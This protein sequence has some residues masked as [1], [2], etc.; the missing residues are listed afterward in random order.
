[1]PQA[2]AI[3][4]SLFPEFNVQ[5]PDDQGYGIRPAKK[6]S[7]KTKTVSED[8][9]IKEHHMKLLFLARD[10]NFRAII[11]S[12]NGMTLNHIGYMFLSQ[13]TLQHRYDRWATNEPYNNVKINIS[14]NYEL[15]NDESLNLFHICEKGDIW[16]IPVTFHIS[17]NR[18]YNNND[19]SIVNISDIRV[20]KPVLNTKYMDNAVIPQS[21]KT[22]MEILRLK[23]PYVASWLEQ[24]PGFKIGEY[25][26]APWAETLQKAG[27]DIGASILK[28]DYKYPQEIE[29][30]NRLCKRGT[31]PKEIFKTSKAVYS[32]LQKDT[33]LALWDTYR[34]LD[35]TGKVNQDTIKTAHDTGWTVKNLEAANAILAKKFDGKPVFTWIS[36]SNY[37]GRLDMYEAICATEALPL[38]NDYLSMCAQLNMQPRIDGDSLKRE[39][40]VAARLVRQHR[41]EIMARKMKEKAEEEAKQIA[42]GDSKLAR[43]EYHE[44]VYFVRPITEYDDLIDEATQ[45]HN[46]VAAYADRIAKRQ[47]RIFTMRETDHP[48]KSLVTIELS[49]DCRTVRQKYLAYNHPIHN[50]SMTDFI[51]RWMKQLNS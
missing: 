18:R 35:K 23:K 51:D 43:C 45:Q 9:E 41:D 33:N 6:E 39:H 50:K 29:R 32:I 12:P 34:K 22:I 40:D 7:V 15:N 11:G 31:N 24:N 46:C 26:N 37:L 36:L 21:D 44:N 17:G 13:D 8:K 3:M 10:N 16:C 1:M 42:E 27:Y 48:E 49:P 14:N 5:T 19:A 4:P 47:T 2:I 25:L 38:L 20:G 28:G 30:F